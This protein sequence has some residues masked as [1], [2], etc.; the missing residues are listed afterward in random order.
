MFEI[1]AAATA[2]SSADHTATA[3]SSADH[4]ATASSSADHAATASS[5]ADQDQSQVNCTFT[6][7]GLCASS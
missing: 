3:S 1:G 5:S 6:C 2:S 4:T 7:T